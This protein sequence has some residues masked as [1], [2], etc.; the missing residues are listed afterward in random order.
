MVKPLTMVFT[1]QD[2]KGGSGQTLINA[3]GLTSS[4]I[5]G[6]YA[7]CETFQGLIDALIKGYIIR[8]GVVVDIPLI[9]GIKTSPDVNAD[10][11]EGA[12]FIWRASTDFT[13]E[14]RIPTFD[15]SKII[16]GTRQVDLLDGDV[17]NFIT[18]MLAG[19][20]RDSRNDP[21]VLMLSAQ[22]DFGRSRT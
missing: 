22:E 5:G 14:N 21:L 1:I 9:G 10:L 8:A 12:K 20:I 4:D 2:G 6:Q 11:E 7:T 17:D 15:E 3:P 18:A 16:T 19:T 13:A